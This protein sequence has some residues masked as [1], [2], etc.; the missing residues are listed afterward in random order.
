MLVDGDLHIGEEI[1]NTLDLVQ[2]R[3]FGMLGEKRP[4]ITAREFLN[5]GSLEG[6]I[7]LV[8]KYGAAKSGLARLTRARDRDDRELA[9]QGAEAGFED[10]PDHAEIIA[11]S[12][13][14]VNMI[15]N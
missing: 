1:G 5:V 11:R 12:V 6:D 7:G 3:S 8:G 13:L 2:H 14:I 4:R 10:P 9:R 15:I